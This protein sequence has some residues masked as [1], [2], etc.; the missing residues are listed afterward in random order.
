MPAPDA[1]SFERLALDAIDPAALLRD[2]T[3]T[4]AAALAELRTSILAHGLRMPIEVFELAEPHGACRYGL[5]SGYRRLAAHRALAADGLAAFAT[6]PA[7]VRA[8]RSI[9][10]AMT[11][12]AEENAIRADVSPWEQAA[13]A[14][15]ARDR[16]IFPTVDAAIDGLYASL[17]RDRRYRMRTI[18]HLVE[19]LDGHLTAPETLSLR[20]LLRLAAATARGYGDLM[21]HALTESRHR[22]PDVQWRLL[23][24]ILAECEDTTIPDPRPERGPPTAPAAPSAPRPAPSPSAASAPPTAGASTSPAATPKAASSTGFSTRSRRSSERGERGG[25]LRQKRTFAPTDAQ[26]LHGG[27][28]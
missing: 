28:D 27:S 9:A 18:A 26:V 14:V 3:Q 2:R 1:P 8:P 15:A 19:E 13:L 6:I 24:P 21:R 16:A 7:F 10:E 23:Q 4:D 11:A 5:I 25:A 12:M 17:S 22:E 20:R